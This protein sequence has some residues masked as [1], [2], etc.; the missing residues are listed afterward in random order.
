MIDELHGIPDN[1]LRKQALDRFWRTDPTLVTTRPKVAWIAGE[2]LKRGGWSEADLADMVHIGY[3]ILGKADVL[4]TWDT[5]DLARE[6]TR[7]I[8][9]AL[10]RQEG[11][12]TPDIATPAEVL[13]EWLGIKIL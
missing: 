11:Y 3:A 8:V 2:L 1:P 6:K 4:V 13:E 7:R 12:E 5:A 9:A 10:G